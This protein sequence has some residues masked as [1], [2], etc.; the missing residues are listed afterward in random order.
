[1]TNYGSV[2]KKGDD[3]GGR[4]NVIVRRQNSMDA[5]KT[6]LISGCSLCDGYV[7]ERK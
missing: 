4:P 7:M 2:T 6:S 1:M 5:S 3:L